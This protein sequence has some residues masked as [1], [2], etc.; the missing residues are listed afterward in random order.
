MYLALQLV[1]SLLVIYPTMLNSFPQGETSNVSLRVPAK[2]W[3]QV[4]LQNTNTWQWT[5]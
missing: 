3:P 1:P 4:Y 5:L 2:G